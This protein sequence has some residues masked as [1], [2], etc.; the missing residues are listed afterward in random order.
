MSLNG[1]KLNNMPPLSGPNPP[2]PPTNLITQTDLEKHTKVII[3]SINNSFSVKI[4]NLSQLLT[5][6]STKTEAQFSSVND[7]I[8]LVSTKTNENSLLTNKWASTA[9]QNRDQC[10]ALAAEA[11][12]Q[13][14][15]HRDHSIIVDN[16]IPK[17]CHGNILTRSDEIRQCLFD[18]IIK[19]EFIEATKGINI[20]GNLVK[21]DMTEDMV[22]SAILLDKAHPLGHRSYAAA[23]VGATVEVVS[24]SGES[25][26]DARPARP[27]SSP[28]HIIRFTNRTSAELAFNLR[29][30]IKASVLA[31]F[32]Q[33]IKIKKDLTAAN[34]SLMTF[35]YKSN[36]VASYG[37][38]KDGNPGSKKVKVE[39]GLV[40]FCKSNTPS[41]FEKVTDPYT[42]DLNLMTTAMI[43]ISIYH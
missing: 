1:D 25:L 13:Q 10:N 42:R 19:K 22:C 29:H 18:N 15:R 41:K 2:N 21:L 27:P 32:N 5:N 12:Y 9:T 4:D 37:P 16:F 33:R 3:E 38:D 6:L 39:A 26:E 30:R 28:S 34:R 24:G 23:A 43:P 36:Q 20:N 14:Q 35:L 40:R 7:K 11:N 31:N 8:D 17:D